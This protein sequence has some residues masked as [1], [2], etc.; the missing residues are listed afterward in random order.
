MTLGMLGAC[1]VKAI[2]EA[3]VCVKQGALKRYNTL[4]ESYAGAGGRPMSY[5]F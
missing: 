4:A 2:D 5:V 1:F 3:L